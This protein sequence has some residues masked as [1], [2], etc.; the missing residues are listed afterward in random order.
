MLNPR[1]RAASSWVVVVGLGLGLAG[2]GPKVT[3]APPTNLSDAGPNHR[4]KFKPEYKK[5]IGPG[6]KMLWKPGQPVPKGVRVPKP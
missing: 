5:M 3:P 2:C 4:L 1:I 6:G